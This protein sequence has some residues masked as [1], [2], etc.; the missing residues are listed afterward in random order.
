MLAYSIPEVG[1][2]S[3][4][5]VGINRSCTVGYIRCTYVGFVNEQIIKH[6]CYGEVKLKK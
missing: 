3:P 5:H 1:R 6:R 4:K 2:I